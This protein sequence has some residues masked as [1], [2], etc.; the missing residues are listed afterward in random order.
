MFSIFSFWALHN[1]NFWALKFPEI[2]P[3]M[4][5]AMWRTQRILNCTWIFKSRKRKVLKCKMLKSMETSGQI[6]L[7]LLLQFSQISS[8]CSAAKIQNI[9]TRISN[10]KCRFQFWC[11]CNSRKCFPRAQIQNIWSQNILTRISNCPTESEYIQI[12]NLKRKWPEYQI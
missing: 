9:L 6:V 3:R 8:A 11:C 7:L 10:I 12:S 5:P 1:Y 2:P 4:C